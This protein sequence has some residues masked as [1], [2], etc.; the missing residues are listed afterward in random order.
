MDKKDRQ[1]GDTGN[2]NISRR[3]NKNQKIFNHFAPECDNYIF[4]D[5][6]DADFSQYYTRQTQNRN[7]YNVNKTATK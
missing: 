5:Q 2:Q 1:N 7:C 3:T 4:T 6:D